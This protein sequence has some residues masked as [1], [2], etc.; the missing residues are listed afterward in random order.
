MHEAS[1]IY[2]REIGKEISSRNIRQT[3][4]QAEMKLVL[5]Q[6]EKGRGGRRC[7][8]EVWVGE[9]QGNDPGEVTKYIAEL[10]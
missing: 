6:P 3:D 4:V 7:V 10:M 9:R 5:G 1:S 2:D 8:E